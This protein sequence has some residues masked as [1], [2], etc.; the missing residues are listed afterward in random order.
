MML[1]YFTSFFKLFR[2]DVI[3]PP[4]YGRIERLRSNGRWV[5]TKRFFNR[6][7]EKG[8]LRYRQVKSNP[9]SDYFRFVASVPGSD[10][11]SESSSDNNDPN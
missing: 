10:I 8:K 4:K 2:F 6:Q 11:V 3:Q 9:S 1:K 5:T 7:L